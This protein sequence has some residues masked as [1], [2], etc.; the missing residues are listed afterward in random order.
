MNASRDPLADIPI[1]PPVPIVPSGRG[2]RVLLAA[3]VLAGALAATW[4]LWEQDVFWQVRA[5]RELL[6]TGHW[7]TVD[8]WSYSALGGTW[9]NFQWLS[10]LPLALF[11]SVGGIAGLVV[12]RDLAVGAVLLLTLVT[13]RQRGAPVRLALLLLGLAWLACARRFQ[14]RSDLFVT[15]VFTAVLVVESSALAWRSRRAALVTLVVLAANLHPGTA[16]F[17]QLAALVALAADARS[18]RREIL[19]AL[20]ILLGLFVTPYHVWVAPYLWHHFFYAA[21]SAVPNPDHRSLLWSHFLP[22]AGGCGPMAWLA[23]VLAAVVVLLRRVRSDGRKLRAVASLACLALLAAMSVNRDRVM[24][25]SAIFAATRIADCFT[26]W[27]LSAR[28]QRI[29]ALAAIAIWLVAIPWWLLRPEVRFGLGLDERMYPVGAARFV[30]ANRPRPQLLHF[31]GDGNYLLRALP[32]YPVFLDTRESM[33]KGLA[34]TYRDM[35]NDPGLFH[36]VMDRYGV[37]TVL[38]PELFLLTPWRDQVSRRAAFLPKGAWALVYFDDTHALFV[39][40]M[41]EHAQLIGAHE[42][43]LLLPYRDPRAYLAT[44]DRTAERDQAFRREVE[45]CR[46]EVPKLAHCQDAQA[47]LPSVVP[48]K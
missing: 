40:R 45:R 42:Y 48:G 2:T 7:P 10:T 21:Y 4:R 29:S 24:P 9:R 1:V 15:V 25:Y 11:D 26:S 27:P 37:N 19:P 31:E 13:L 8:T 39:R 5:G 12:L 6:A 34:A 47:A 17:V 43:E 44:Q 14:V 41:P 22:S 3:T 46:K 23:L 38:V 36:A 33:Y 20:A 35:V 32:D 16:P 30:T 18:W 28:V